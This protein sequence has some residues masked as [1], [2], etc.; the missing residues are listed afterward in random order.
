MAA[1]SRSP[2]PRP[3][4]GSHRAALR[5]VWG[6]GA[7]AASPGGVQG[8]WK[9][10]PGPKTHRGT[11]PSPPGAMPSPGAPRPPGAPRSPSRAPSPTEARP[12]LSARDSPSLNRPRSDSTTATLLFMVRPSWPLRTRPILLWRPFANPKPRH[13]RRLRPVW[14]YNT[15]T[16]GRCQ[17][18]MLN[19]FWGRA[20]G[21]MKGGATAF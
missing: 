21:T 13:P 18:R 1:P 2:P 3:A 14:I 17:A 12:A 4:A 10:P 11:F 16:F 15:L 5:P 8:V 6:V 9:S 20:C 19:F 7:R